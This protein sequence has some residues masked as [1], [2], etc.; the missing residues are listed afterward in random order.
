MGWLRERKE[1]IHRGNKPDRKALQG[2]E[3]LVR[4]GHKEHKVH[5]GRNLEHMD[6]IQACTKE[7]KKNRK[8]NILGHKDHIQRH[9]DYKDHIHLVH[10]ESSSMLEDCNCKIHQ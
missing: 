7:G 5:K 6:D 10:K 4:R 9:T 8:E 1:C 3:H 2:N